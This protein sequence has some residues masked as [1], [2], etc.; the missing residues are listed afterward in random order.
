MA[1]DHRPLRADSEHLFGLFDALSGL[2]GLCLLWVMFVHLPS[3]AV[4]PGFFTHIHDHWRFGVD[5]FLAISGFLVMR[6]LV[7][8]HVL[9]ERKQRGYWSAAKEYLVRRGARIWPSYYA[10]L[11]ILGGL[12]L[13]TRGAFL[14]QLREVGAPLVAFPLFFANYVI[15]VLGE[16]L[17]HSLIIL[18]SVSF[19]EQFYFLL[20]GLYLLT[21][22]RLLE[23]LIALGSSSIVLRL[24][25]VIF[26]WDPSVDYGSHLTFWLPLAFDS[27]TWGCVAW[28]LYDELGRAWS[29]PRRAIV[30]N[31]AIIAATVA[32]IAAPSFF[33]GNLAQALIATLKAPLLA[34]S[35]RMVC[36]WK[37][38][39]GRFLSF[40]PLG[41]LG[42]VSYEVYLLHVVVYGFVQK[43]GP[44]I[45]VHG[46]PG[47][48]LLAYPTS[49]ALGWAFYTYFG[50]PAQERLKLVLRRVIP[51]NAH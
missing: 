50:R 28:L 40:K 42:L 36:E 11:I 25:W 18:W 21:R 2:R 39:A 22:H 13:L 16:S 33:Q 51:E 48:L 27:L 23:I 1:E 45:G 32:V 14:E 26:V 17:P 20:A 30:A 5:F 8:C 29:T 4:P 35:V 44:K 24:I 9:A 43:I 41:T 34:L 3:D 47:F 38:L 46:G 31:L 12:A 19:Q 37:G 7:Q 6:S 15:P 10:A 49:L